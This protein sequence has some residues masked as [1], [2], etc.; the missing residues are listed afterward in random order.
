MCIA[1]EVVIV[2]AGA[3]GLATGIFLGRH[4]PGTRIVGLDG[5]QK[6]GAKI[7]VSG[8]GRCNVTNVRVTPADFLGGNPNVIRR[9]LAA[10][11]ESATRDFFSEI[12]VALHEEEWGKLFPDS[13]SA[14]TVVGAL[15]AE[16]KRVGVEVRAGHRVTDLSRDDAGFVVTMQGP[17]GAIELRSRFVVLATGGKSLPKTGSDG[18]GYTLAEKLGHTLIPT[19]PALDPL[20]L[21]GDF[22]LS[23]SGVA[24]EVELTAHI[25]GARPVR[26]KGPMLW[27]HFGLSGP[28]ALDVSRYW[29]R[30]MIEGIAV[31]IT[32][33]FA[34]GAEFAA[35]EGALIEAAASQ[36]RSY[37]STV[38]RR[39]VP[40][41][42]S[43][44]LCRSAG[45][46][47][48][49][50]MGRLTREGRRSLVHHMV[51]WPVPVM[52]TRGYKF[53]EVTAGGIPLS[54]INPSTMESRVC[55]GLYLVG[56]ILDVDGRIGG[57]NFQWAWS[58]GFVAG[59]S[60]G[61]A[62]SQP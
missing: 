47:T 43:E 16:A 61:K 57:F 3:A 45:V 38:L 4:R 6:I 60:L 59:S 7:L 44:A 37:V 15:L 46:P 23:L 53:A 21:S 62:L 19:T 18:F 58:S 11:P 14:R 36:P 13:D 26:I 8:G 52:G 10:F 35:V 42:V 31:R 39:W 24:H 49:L 9:I 30:A 25:A 28:A 17:A 12:G 50:E 48:S 2:G 20:V 34:G 56:E 54:E 55:P 29:N 41:R 22:H 27:T 33:N 51:E 5:A 32:A 40:A 1:A